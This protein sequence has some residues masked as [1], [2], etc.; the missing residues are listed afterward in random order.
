MRLLMNPSGNLGGRPGPG[1]PPSTQSGC[2]GC[3]ATRNPPDGLVGG[4]CLRHT[5]S[6]QGRLRN[7]LHQPRAAN[8]MGGLTQVFLRNFRNTYRRGKCVSAQVGPSAHIQSH[9][10]NT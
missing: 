10:R 3:L 6:I 4:L 2:Y 1:P 8:G 7:Y 9:C 5:S